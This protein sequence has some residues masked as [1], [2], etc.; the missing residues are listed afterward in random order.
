M[1]AELGLSPPSHPP[2][3][4]TTEM[5]GAS[6][7]RI[8][9]GCLDPASCPVQLGGSDVRDWA[10]PDPSPLD[11][12]GFREVRDRLVSL[13]RSLRDELMRA[14]RSNAARLRGRSR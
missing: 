10:L 6:Q 5:L 14:E 7:V 12:A 1:L 11:D 3:A 4:V 8:L 13:V 9:M 2:Q